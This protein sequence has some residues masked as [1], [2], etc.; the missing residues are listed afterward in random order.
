MY[1]EAKHYLASL[2][3]GL[4]VLRQP[5]ATKYLAGRYQARGATV[6][7]LVTN[8]SQQGLRF[9]PALPENQPAYFGLYSLL[10]AF[11]AG[12]ESE[13]GFRVMLAPPI[14]DAATQGPSG[15]PRRSSSP[16]PP[17]N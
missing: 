8:M 6:A 16:P 3:D 1:L 14:M 15:D 13:S 10:V 4:A 11:A 17:R 9:G 12:G 2:R 5:D 7:E